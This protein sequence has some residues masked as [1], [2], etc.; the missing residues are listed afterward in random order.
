MADQIVEFSAGVWVEDAENKSDAELR[1]G[2]KE[3][4]DYNVENV[5]IRDVIQ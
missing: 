2:V 3:E 1:R 4:L 5:K